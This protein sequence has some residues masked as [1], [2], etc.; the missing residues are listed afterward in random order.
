LTIP[1]IHRGL[2]GVWP[3]LTTPLQADG[4]VDDARF[5]AHSMALLDAGCAG[6]TPFGTTRCSHVACRPAACWRR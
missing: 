1:S 6:V 4:S 2:H 3:A 5:A